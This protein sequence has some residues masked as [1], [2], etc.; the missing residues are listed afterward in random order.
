MLKL[1]KHEIKQVWS[2]L[3][4]ITVATV[5]IV[6]VQ[7]MLFSYRGNA[8]IGQLFGKMSTPVLIFTLFVFVVV[9]FFTLVKRYQRSMYSDEGYLTAVLPVPI[10]KTVAAKL[11]VATLFT[12][13]SAILVG[14]AVMSFAEIDGEI[15]L[16]HVDAFFKFAFELF[17]KFPLQMLM[18]SLFVLLSPTVFYSYIYLSLAI[19]QLSNRNKVI[20]S[21]IAFVI[22][23]NIQSV[24]MYLL[25]IAGFENLVSINQNNIHTVASTMVFLS[26]VVQIAICYAGTVYLSKNHLNLS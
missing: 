12:W 2:Y 7:R 18:F 6:V 11:I 13:L 22:I 10:W 4:L 20:M 26:T 8:V 16:S 1:I 23:S 3:T 21:I 15:L 17:S 25:A 19:G 24:A 9:V 5:I 14:L